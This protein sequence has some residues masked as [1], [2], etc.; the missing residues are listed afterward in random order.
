MEVKYKL[1]PNTKI[2]KKNNEV[3]FQNINGNLIKISILEYEVLNVFVKKNDLNDVFK[4]LDFNDI[5][6]THQNIKELIDRLIKFEVI[7]NN[8]FSKK[9]KVFN[10][11]KKFQRK[12][13]NILLLEIDIRSNKL[14]LFFLLKYNRY[15]LFFLYI[16]LLLVVCIKLIYYKE[17][18]SVNQFYIKYINSPNVSI[19]DITIL[20]LFLTILSVIF[21]EIGHMIL[22]KF[23]SGIGIKF[24]FG[25][26][27]FVLPTF[28]S[29]YFPQ[30]LTKKE[31]IFVCLGGLFFD[32]LFLILILLYLIYF[33]KFSITFSLTLYF[34]IILLFYRVFYNLNP[35]LVGSDAYKILQILLNKTNIFK[36]SFLSILKLNK[37]PF[38]IKKTIYPTFFLLFICNIIFFWFIVFYP[39]FFYVFY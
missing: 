5:K 4:Y 1:N 18:E 30:T 27:L 26:F 16:L 10:I 36:E 3:Y 35:F 8:D 2:H 28:F 31:N 15:I 22:Y 12:K 21:H 6:Y 37:G 9:F 20:Y 23:F 7:V 34:I 25:L 11:I 24:G 39:V 14:D 17:H 38:N 32:S 13:T 19:R 29:N 33:N